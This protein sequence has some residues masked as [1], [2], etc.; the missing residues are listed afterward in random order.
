MTG[1]SEDSASGGPHPPIDAV[2]DEPLFEKVGATEDGYLYEMNALDVLI[3]MKGLQAIK[4]EK[5]AN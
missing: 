5:D 3:Y 1:A 2:H 4:E